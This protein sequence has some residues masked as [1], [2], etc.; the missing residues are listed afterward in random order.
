MLVEIN[1]LFGIDLPLG[2]I[3]QYPTIKQ[4]ASIISSGNRQSSWYSLVPIQTQ[5]L[6]PPLFA[7]HTI[8]LQDLPRHLGKDQPLYFLR[9]GMAAEHND[10]PIKLPAL[11]ELASHYI[12]ELQQVQPEGPYY[13]AGFSFGGVIAYE[14]ARQL[15]ANGHEVNLVALL[16]T[17]LDWEKQWLPLHRIIHKFFRQSPKR[18]LT[19]A[20]NKITGLAT[21]SKNGADFWPHIYTLAP[22]VSCRESYQPKSYIGRVILFQAS[23]WETLFFSYA[24]PEQAWKK[25]M[26]DRLDVQQI[27]GNHFEIFNEPHVQ[28]LAEKLKA[29]MDV[30]INNG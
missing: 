24:P 13:L 6:R 21:S 1:K 27:S 25:L 11:E 8:T 28:H 30:S 3:Y 17:Y 2:T 26:N 7:V 16:D 9:Y 10:H 23:V 18:L 20:K 15:Q 14:M 19:L 29:C 5:G 4:L 12:K 22:N